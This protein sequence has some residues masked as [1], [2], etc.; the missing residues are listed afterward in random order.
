MRG[1]CEEDAAEHEK[2]A[3]MDVMFVAMVAMLTIVESL[4]PQGAFRF[5]FGRGRTDEH[6]REGCR[7]PLGIAD[8]SRVVPSYREARCL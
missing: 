7:A 4:Y 8:T 3:A 6:G 2:R 5:F 1:A